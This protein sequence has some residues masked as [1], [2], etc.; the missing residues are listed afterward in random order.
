MRLEEIRQRFEN[1]FVLIEVTKALRKN[2]L[3]KRNAAD[4]LQ[5]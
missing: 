5:A 4:K 1:E 3:N 2:K